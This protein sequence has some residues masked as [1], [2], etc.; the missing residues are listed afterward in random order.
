MILGVQNQINMLPNQF[1]DRFNQF[2]GVKLEELLPKAQEFF[3][4]LSAEAE[5]RGHLS[6]SHSNTL[7]HEK[8]LWL[9]TERIEGATEAIKRLES[10]YELSYSD[11]LADE[12]KALVASWVTEIWCK[13][14]IDTCSPQGDD[15]RVKY[16]G[17]LFR[18]RGSALNKANL[19]IDLLVDGI[20]NRNQTRQSESKELEQK[21]EILWSARQAKIDFEGW[22]EE[23]RPT[24]GSI[25]VLFVDLD[26]FKAL[27]TQYTETIIDETILPDAMR[28]VQNLV[29]LRG[30]AYRHGGEE[31]LVILPNYMPS[32][33]TAFA[34]RLRSAFESTDFRV[35][36]QAERLTVSIGVA[37]WPQHGSS[38]DEVLKSANEAESEAKHSKNACVLAKK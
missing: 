20:R 11:K 10:S 18:V 3:S 37:L 26:N 25:A 6:R 36:R 12:L 5:K 27:N 29:R 13:Q 35:K 14:S 7:H 21:F 38:Y 8:V 28:L 32:E 17:D 31:F 2:M 9:A 34:E 33:A 1:T 4:R 22:A 23:L 24:S 16:E 30:G 19:E 15:Q